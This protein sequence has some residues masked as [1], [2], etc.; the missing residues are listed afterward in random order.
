VFA[1]TYREAKETFLPDGAVQKVA[2]FRFVT[3]RDPP[4][5]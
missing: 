2:V 4:Q 5:T 1:T 3:F